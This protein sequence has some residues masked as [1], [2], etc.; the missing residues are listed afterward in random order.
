MLLPNC[1]N[2]RVCIYVCVLEKYKKLPSVNI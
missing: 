1:E 2:K